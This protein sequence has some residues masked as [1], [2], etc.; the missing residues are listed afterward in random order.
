[1]TAITSLFV[2]P[3][4]LELQ[5]RVEIFRFDDG[6]LLAVADGAGGM[7]RGAQA[8]ELCMRLISESA[9]SL[10]TPEA[11][12]DLLQAIDL[13]LTSISECGQT[14][15]LVLV[16][17]PK[18]LFGASV[19]D[20]MAWAFTANERIELTQGQQRKPFLGSGVA[21]CRTFQFPMVA[22]TIVVAT[23]GLWKYTSLESIERRVGETDPAKLA[24]EL[25]QLVRLRSGG[26]PDDVAIATCRLT[27]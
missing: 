18:R 12:A 9:Q 19:G 11:C 20:S 14:T 23:D 4:N 27:V 13:K 22:G 3:G 16:I 25:P 10:R 21:F 24:T 2:A 26:F 8:A 6:V 7:S 17:E 15:G 5:D 1:M